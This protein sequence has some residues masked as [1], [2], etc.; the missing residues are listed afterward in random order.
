MKIRIIVNP[1]AGTSS[2]VDDVS[3]AVG[4]VFGDEGGIF[5][6]RTTGKQGDGFRL[7]KEARDKGYE[8]VFA[9]GGDGTVNEVASALVDG[10]GECS[11]ILGIIRCGSGNGLARAL[12]IPEGIEKA[13]RLSIDGRVRPVDTGVVND[14]YFFATA[15]FGFD[16]ALSKRYS[17]TTKR[18]GILPYF[19]LAMKE[20][21]SYKPEATI[22][23][24]D[25]SYL[26]VFPF[27]LTVANTDQYGAG[28]VIAPGAVPDD[29]LLDL[30]IIQDVGLL[31][32]TTY[33][34]R[35]FKGDIDKTKKFKR[36][37]AASME[38]VRKRPGPVHLDG[39]S[40]HG[41]EKL[42]VSVIPKALKVWVS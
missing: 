27:I 38:I 21:F 10:T 19:P 23:K 2:V 13:L 15:G 3:E 37:R 40:Y 35:L 29:G 12:G 20:F 18:R 42:K 24:Y 6:V 11:T 36:I 28:C 9:C 1:R 16:A 7:S 17:E 32:A 4:R 14:E 22:I 31:T 41:S 5:E 25:D 39:E 8:T 26:R 30:C 33:T 34:R